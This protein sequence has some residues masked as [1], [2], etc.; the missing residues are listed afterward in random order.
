MPHFIHSELN[1]L[2]LKMYNDQFFFWMVCNRLMNDLTEELL[3]K[4]RL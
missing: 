1:K 4:L 3:D 2:K